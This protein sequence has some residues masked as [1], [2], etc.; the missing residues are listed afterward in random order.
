MNGTQRS[1]TCAQGTQYAEQGSDVMECP[2][3]TDTT[4]K[5]TCPQPSVPVPFELLLLHGNELGRPGRHPDADVF[6]RLEQ[7][8]CETGSVTPAA[9]VNT[10]H[11]RAIQTPA[12]EDCITEVVERQTLKRSGDM[13]RQLGP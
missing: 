12:N 4:N 3:N 8:P 10:G 13:A 11:P 5:A 6:R 2:W 7:R 9:H 1:V